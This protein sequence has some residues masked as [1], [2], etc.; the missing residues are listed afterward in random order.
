MI[1]L[2]II[3]LSRHARRHPHDVDPY[4]FYFVK[5]HAYSYY[6]LPRTTA[7]N[8]VTEVTLSVLF[9]VVGTSTSPTLL[10]GFNVDPLLAKMELNLS[11]SSSSGKN[12]RVMLSL[13]QSKSNDLKKDHE[14]NKHGERIHNKQMKYNLQHLAPSYHM[15]YLSDT[16]QKLNKN[17]YK[18]KHF[19]IPV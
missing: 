6:M 2:R 17:L 9:P 10:L 14:P 16:S 5:I 7:L 13:N 12:V 4:Y 8:R 1:S 18:A 11:S 3:P 19:T 15:L